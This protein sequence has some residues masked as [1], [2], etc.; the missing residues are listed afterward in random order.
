MTN[1]VIEPISSNS[2]DFGDKHVIMSILRDKIYS[3]PI[4][5]ICQEISSNARD[6]HA[7]VGKSDTPISITLPTYTNLFFEVKD[8]GP[9]ITPE[10]M[11]DVFIK[12]GNTTKKDSKNQLGG[13]GLGSKSPF[14]YT[15]TFSIIS[16]TGGVSRKYEA[17]IDAT[18]VGL[19]NLISET[20]SVEST[21]VTI[22]IP[23]K[24]N[25]QDISDFIKWTITSTG[26]W[27][28]RPIL[29]GDNNSLYR[30]L[31][32]AILFRSDSGGL[33]GNNL[34]SFNFSI[35]KQSILIDGIPYPLNLFEA[36]KDSQYS[37]PLSLLKNFW[38]S[39]GAKEVKVSANRELIEYNKETCELIN[40]KINALVTEIKDKLLSDIKNAPSL[41]E[42]YIVWK[43][44]QLKNFIKSA[45]WN[46]I[47][48]DFKEN[49]LLSSNEIRA[50][51]RVY[52]ARNNSHKSIGFEIDENSILVDDNIGDISVK[53]RITNYLLNNTKISKAF[54]FKFACDQDRQ[55]FYKEY[56]LKDLQIVNLSSMVLP[57]KK[58]KATTR[59]KI[60]IIKELS[61][62]SW[63]PSS[64]SLNPEEE[65]FYIE[66][67]ENKPLLNGKSI[68]FASLKSLETS[69]GRKVYG[70]KKKH[71]KKLNQ[72]WVKAELKILAD[73]SDLESK[74]N[75][76]KRISYLGEVN[77][78][79][80]PRSRVYDNWIFAMFYT[81]REKLKSSLAL[82]IADN[83][84][85]YELSD[86]NEIIKYNF[87]SKIIGKKLNFDLYKDDIANPIALL[88][89]KY[90]LLSVIPHQYD[91][92]HH[93]SII[94]YINTVEN[95]Q[96][97]KSKITDQQIESESKNDSRQEICN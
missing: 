27:K 64:I 73:I 48:F 78:Y 69:L 85:L 75:L 34:Y 50:S 80:A 89:A 17:K 46:G 55:S 90:P 24:N 57:S 39:V 14:A 26:F 92:K 97:L 42:A 6:A 8:T 84:N 43:K 30:S 87:L 96:E 15:N 41:K 60:S 65:Q 7:E 63:K 22:T 70:I 33:L 93:Q 13:F 3:N 56:H 66:I 23:V 83:Y 10:R 79:Y 9:G 35:T 58:P 68:D 40:S 32:S 31:E 72:K 61:G 86:K 74:P 88:Y 1:T 59:N 19:L 25:H 12:Y 91:N 29:S 51:I 76:E 11:N 45:D 5:T 67:D 38:V 52:Y 82:K 47:N 37:E 94:D 62:Y 81:H 44:S 49:L 18:G 71:F 53:S 21:G 16:V 2:F 54:I 95:Y 20:N 4:K 28:T 36:V 77:N